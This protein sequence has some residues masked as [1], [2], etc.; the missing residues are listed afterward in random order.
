MKTFEIWTD[1]AEMKGTEYTKGMGY[2]AGIM[3]EAHML[4]SFDTLSEAQDA[5]RKYRCSAYRFR[6]NGGYDMLKITEYWIDEVEYGKDQNGDDD[7]LYAD[8]VE[9]AEVSE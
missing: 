5:L 4:E 9:F 7:I 6:S 8:V 2:N 1:T 3:T